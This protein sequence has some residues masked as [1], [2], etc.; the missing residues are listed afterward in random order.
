MPSRCELQLHDPV[1]DS[2]VH[3]HTERRPRELKRQPRRIHVNGHGGRCR[4][5]SIR[6]CNSQYS[7]GFCN[8]HDDRARRAGRSVQQPP[9]NRRSRGRCRLS[10]SVGRTTNERPRP[11]SGTDLVYTKS[12]HA[13]ADDGSNYILQQLWKRKPCINSVM[14]QLRKQTRV[15][16]NKR[17]IGH[18]SNFR[19]QHRNRSTHNGC[20]GECVYTQKRVCV[21]SQEDRETETCTSPVWA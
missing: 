19:R 11:T 18:S 12:R 17:I 8:D 21:H 10:H 3:V 14:H 4:R 15:K 5:R 13:A 1:R 7:T 6:N 16:L 2:A 20:C 9:R